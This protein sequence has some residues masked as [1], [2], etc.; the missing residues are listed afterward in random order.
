MKVLNYD[1]RK[2]KRDISE[3]VVYPCYAHTI[4]PSRASLSN[5]NIDREGARA[6]AATLRT[7]TAL[8]KL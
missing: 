1:N 3:E 6:L 2:N 8:K 7:N 4:T 5:N